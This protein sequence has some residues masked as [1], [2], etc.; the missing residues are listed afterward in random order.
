MNIPLQG[1][2]RRGVS[3]HLAERFDLKS[4]LDT[5]GGEGVPERVKVNVLNTA[6]GAVLLYLELQYTRLYI[7]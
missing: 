3:E 6:G 2:L 1:D 7:F 4:D 5:S